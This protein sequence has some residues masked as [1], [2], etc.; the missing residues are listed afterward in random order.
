MT[1]KGKIVG[2]RVRGV[3]LIAEFF[4]VTPRTVR[5][6]RGEGAPIS[7]QGEADLAEVQRWLDRRRGGVVAGG[8]G[9]QRYLEP[10]QG[11]E[12]EEIRLKRAQA[13]KIE[14]ELRVR[15]GELIERSEV[16]QLL[17]ARIMAVKQGL[18]GLARALPPQ[19]I[20]CQAEREMEAIIARSVRDLLE[21]YARPLSQGRGGP[22]SGGSGVTV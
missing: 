4:E 15:R 18:Q 21:D 20:H 17:V 12:Y 6:W 22:E 11:K 1:E 7:R 13:D 9:R 10:Q 16:E 3:K 19:L 8:D 5:N 2:S 14:Q